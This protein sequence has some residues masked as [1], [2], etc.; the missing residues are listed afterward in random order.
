MSSAAGHR[1]MC[2]MPDS[3][4]HRLE[5][6]KRVNRVIDHIQ[7]HLGDDLSLAALARVAAFSPFH[8]HRLFKAITGETVFGFIHR[9]RVER[10]AVA[11][12][13]HAD[14]SVL[15]VA[16]DH[17]FSSAATFA[18]A[19][20]ARF[21]MSATEWRDGGAARWRAGRAP[22]NQGK[23]LRKRGKAQRGGRRETRGRKEERAMAVHVRDLPAYHVAYMRYVGPY[24]DHGIPE[25]WTK[26]TR[27]M[28]THGLAADT[29]VKLGVA[30]DDPT[31]TAPEK[32]RYDACVV[33]PAGFAADR[34]VNLA[35]MPGGR[36]AVTEFTGTAR[37][38][39]AAWEHVFGAWLPGS[40]YE[41]DDRPCFEIY[42]GNPGVA[43]KS[44]T[45][46]CELCLPVRP[47]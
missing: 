34:W 16:L 32:C 19:F 42:R 29:A 45:F 27:W 35:D 37:D 33:V 26:L 2:A 44:G 8:F 18:R 4:I 11:L 43:G 21:G 17:G 12:M 15:A 24:G 36:C 20:R 10:A 9:L 31:V 40:G 14:Q 23:Q 5:Y 30:Y 7:R 6:E 41:P 38:I 13:A 28:E 25:L 22:R 1:I 46:R 47:M 3:G 39:E